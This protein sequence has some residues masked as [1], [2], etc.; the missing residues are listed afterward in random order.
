MVLLWVSVQ[1]HSVLGTY[2]S[3]SL[4]WHLT[5]AN[6]EIPNSCQQVKPESMEKE[7]KKERELLKVDNY[8]KENKGTFC[9]ERLSE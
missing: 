1:S 8:I 3:E 4:G 2:F 9:V 5:R 7:K 6:L